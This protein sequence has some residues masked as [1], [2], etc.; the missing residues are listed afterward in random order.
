MPDIPADRSHIRTEHTNQASAGLH[1]FSIADCV[2]LISDEDTTIAAAVVEASTQICDL[3]ESAAPGF[4]ADGRLIYLGAGTSGRL[5]VLDASE[6]PPTF[7]VD[8]GKVVG[9]IAG[10]DRS[11]RISSESKEDH[12][13]GAEQELIDLNLTPHD[14]LVGIAAGG[15][16][17]YV[18][19]AF[20]IAERLAP[21][22]T[23]AMLTCTPIEQPRDCK[24]L[25]VVETG[26]EVLTGSTRMKAGTATKMVLNTISTTLMI[27]A[28][29]VYDN[30]MV[31]MKPTNDKLL[32]RAA[33]VVA[34]LTGLDRAQSLALL[35]D[36]GDRVKVAVVMH[37]KDLPRADAEQILE[38]T[39]DNLATILDAHP[40]GTTG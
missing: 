26:P 29:R 27:Q 33:R 17:P 38:S 10:G 21:G 39:G 35:A 34:Q 37:R 4:C 28:G 30:L 12:L 25:I 11:L 32:D 16:T 6:A 23:T 31:D 13:D 36:A 8:P 1:A 15:T 7:C 2:K 40:S 22:I 18:L 5:G 3:I 20:A 9:I 24:H 14:T 19:G